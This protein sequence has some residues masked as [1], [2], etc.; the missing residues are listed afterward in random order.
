M[1]DTSSSSLWGMAIL[2]T[3]IFFTLFAQDCNRINTTCCY[4]E[5]FDTS[6]GKCLIC[7]H[8]SMGLNC[9]ISCRQGY[10]GYLCRSPC[11]CEAH[12]CDKETGCQQR[13]NK[14]SIDVRDNASKNHDWIAASLSIMVLIVVSVICAIV[15]NFRRSLFRYLKRSANLCLTKEATKSQELTI[16]Q[17]QDCVPVE[18]V[19]NENDL[20]SDYDDIRYSQCIRSSRFNCGDSPLCGNKMVGNLV[21]AK[22]PHLTGFHNAD[23]KV[24]DYSRLLLRKNTNTCIL[25]KTAISEGEGYAFLQKN[26]EKATAESSIQGRQ[27]LSRISTINENDSVG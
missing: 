20:S 12:L 15:L 8:G 11:E 10:Y 27:S 5:Y 23:N 7:R 1:F 14:T 25:V 22:R 17:P 13:Q 21:E 6:T 19:D 18:I 2:I 4:N 9:K 26:Y 16:V 3:K 24:E